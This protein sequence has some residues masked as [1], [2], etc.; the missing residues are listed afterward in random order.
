[1]PYV[2]LGLVL[3][4]LVLKSGVH[5][6]LAGVALAMT[7]PVLDRGGAPVLE[8]MEHALHPWVAFLVVPMFALANAG[9]RADRAGPCRRV[10]A[11]SRWALRWV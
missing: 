11:R 7:V 1:M 5:A 10:A 4:V 2:L 9:V 8:R 6:T 3:W